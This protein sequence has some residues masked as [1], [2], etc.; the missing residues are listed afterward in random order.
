MEGWGTDD[1]TV[2]RVFGTN[3]RQTIQA[4][5]AKY[6][7]L[8]NTELTEALGGEL[9]GNFG[10]VQSHAVWFLSLAV[11]SRLHQCSPFAIV[12]GGPGLHYVL[13]GR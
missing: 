3:D 4:I 5:A 6:N 11:Q 8:Y 10:K 1:D 13:E 9:S 7:E 12:S 2:T